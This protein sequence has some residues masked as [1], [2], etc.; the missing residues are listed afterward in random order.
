MHYAKPQTDDHSGLA[1]TVRQKKPKYTA[2]MFLM[3]RSQLEIPHNTPAVHGDINCQAN[4]R[5]LHP[6]VS[7]P[8]PAPQVADARVRLPD[9]RPQPR[10]RH[11]WL[12]VE[13]RRVLDFP[14]L[15]LPRYTPGDRDQEEQWKMIAKGNPNWPQAFYP[16]DEQMVVNPGD[17]LAAR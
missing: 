17:T 9:P 13:D 2:G 1:V 14:D 15:S 5:Y 10:L 3:L 12:Q 6:V 7:L 11:I 8:P 16:M 4:L